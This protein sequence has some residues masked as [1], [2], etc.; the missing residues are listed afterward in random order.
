MGRGQLARA[1]ARARVKLDLHL[2][3][4]LSLLRGWTLF[5]A[6]GVGGVHFS[7]L[8]Q[9][10]GFRSDPPTHTLVPP[11]AAFALVQSPLASRAS[12]GKFSLSLAN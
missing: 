5:R 12:W 10:L 11:G 9:P 6:A 4:P 3:P 1:W 8:F 2:R 7:F